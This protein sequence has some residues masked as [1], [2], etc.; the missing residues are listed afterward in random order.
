[1][2]AALLCGFLFA[3]CRSA[4]GACH[5]PAD[6]SA[7][8]KRVVLPDSAPALGAPSD[9]EQF[10]AGEPALVWFDGGPAVVGG[11]HHA[12]G[13]MDYT[14][15]FESDNR[16]VLE[17]DFLRDLAGAKVD[18]VAYSGG[19][20]LPLLWE[21]RHGGR[22]LR[23]SWEAHGVYTVVV[24]VHNHLREPPLVSSYRSGAPLI[25][26]A[27][28]FAPAAF[29]E[30]RS[31]YYYHPGGREIALCDAPGQRLELRAASLAGPV[32]VTVTLPAPPAKPGRARR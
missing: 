14:F 12:H 23:V 30:P 11:T 25:V 31:L 8:W 17:V 29:R 1:M 15:Q 22:R 9:L 20:A 24:R 7:G 19:A 10:R 4:Q 21:A 32:P 3:A 27:Q 2:R 26:G 6:Q 18:V 28:P 13:R 5:V 16:R